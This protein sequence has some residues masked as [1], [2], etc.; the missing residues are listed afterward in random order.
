MVA[1]AALGVASIFALYTFIGPFVTLLVPA[2][3]PS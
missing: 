3:S 1:V 2:E